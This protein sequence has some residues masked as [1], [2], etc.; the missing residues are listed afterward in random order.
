VNGNTRDPPSRRYLP[1]SSG[2]RPSS[3]RPSGPPSRR[4]LPRREPRVLR[5]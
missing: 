3:P 2:R 1:D 5:P 4:R